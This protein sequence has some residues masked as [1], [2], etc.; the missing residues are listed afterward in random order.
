VRAV[1]A[2]SGSVV[3]SICAATLAAAGASA[4]FAATV[5]SAPAKDSFVGS[6]TAATGRFSG[7]HGG[8]R[9]VLAPGR[10][11]SGRRLTVTFSGGSC[12]SAG[13]CIQLSGRLTGVLTRGPIVV[14]DVGSSLTVR[15]SGAIRPLGKVSATGSVHGTGFIARGHETLRLK[16]TGS[17]ATIT[18]SADSGLVPGGTSP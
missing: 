11:Q 10:G 9:L 7:D 4:A 3:G 5:G 12:G 8:V 18:I 13:H 6:V 15:A 16:L 2:V 14:P 1:I 17:G